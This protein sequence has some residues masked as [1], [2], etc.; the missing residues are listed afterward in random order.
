MNA[1]HESHGRGMKRA[2]KKIG[3]HP[4]FASSLGRFFFYSFQWKLRQQ[5]RQQ[6]QKTT[7]TTMARD[8]ADD[9]EEKRIR[10]KKLKWRQNCFIRRREEEQK[11][12]RI[13]FIASQLPRRKPWKSIKRAFNSR[14]RTTTRRKIA[15]LYIFSSLALVLESGKHKLFF[16]RWGLLWK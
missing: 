3:F 10:K 9:S 2:A 1:I 5:Q 4:P 7:R 11:R 14:R 13:A 12:R 8:I 15:N 16:Y 6:K